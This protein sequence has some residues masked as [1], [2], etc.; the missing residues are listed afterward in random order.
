MKR[1]R[2]TSHATR[3][4]SSEEATGTIT[5]EQKMLL[6]SMITNGDPEVEE[7]LDQAALGNS[8][9]LKDLAL[10]GGSALHTRLRQL[11]NDGLLPLRFSRGSSQDMSGSV[12]FTIGAGGL[13]E[14]E[15]GGG[16]MRPHSLEMEDGFDLEALLKEMV[17]ADSTTESAHRDMGAGDSAR[18]GR[19]AT[20]A[21]D[22]LSNNLG[23]HLYFDPSLRH[24]FHANN[25][26]DLD[27]SNRG[28]NGDDVAR[29]AIAAA[30]M[31]HQFGGTAADDDEPESP[32][33]RTASEC[34]SQRSMISDGTGEGAGI[35]RSAERSGKAGLLLAQSRA[36]EST[37]RTE[38]SLGCGFQIIDNYFPD[39][40]NR[41]SAS[42]AD[43][44]GASQ[45][46]GKTRQ[47]GGAASGG[48][49]GGDWASR[50]LGESA[51][52]AEED[53]DAIERS[54]LSALDENGG[55]FVEDGDM[56]FEGL[57]DFPDMSDDMI[58]EDLIG[59]TSEDVTV[60]TKPRK[61]RQR[62][63]NAR[64]GAGAGESKS[65]KAKPRTRRSSK[66]DGKSTGG[67]SS[68]SSASSPG[69]FGFNW[70]F[71]L[72]RGS[73]VNEKVSGMTASTWHGAQGASSVT[74]PV[75][76]PMGMRV[77]QMNFVAP[78][79][80]PTH[81]RFGF[82]QMF[83]PGMSPQGGN[84]Q[85]PQQN[86]SAYVM[87]QGVNASWHAGM[88]FQPHALP[89]GMLPQQFS[90]IQNTNVAMRQ[91]EGS[92]LSER[93]RGSGSSGGGETG[94][95]LRVGALSERADILQER[96]LLTP[97]QRGLVQIIFRRG[98][99]YLCTRFDEAMTE[100]EAGRTDRL[101]ELLRMAERLRELPPPAGS[102][103]TALPA[104]QNLGGTAVNASSGAGSAGTAEAPSSTAAAASPPVATTA[105]AVEQLSI[106]EL[107]SGI[108]SLLSAVQAS[109][110]QAV[111][112]RNSKQ[113]D[114]A[115]KAMK[116]M[117]EEEAKLAAYQ[118]ALERRGGTRSEL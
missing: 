55:D 112:L 38:N 91:S 62:G 37:S 108:N 114:L 97:H 83:Q 11:S 13:A 46:G 69:S 99:D 27:M 64:R 84:L 20:R 32:R 72:T 78:Q 93:P 82:Q 79:S 4:L 115:L 117:K 44:V 42:P 41:G 36:R 110:A 33:K 65:A 59:Q 45:Q 51:D 22:D 100:A 109:K 70:P 77:N 58:S 95:S 25:S 63:T 21:V 80:M 94:R 102:S 48:G 19:D 8:Q 7:A 47:G 68:G 3:L 50:Q 60:D 87:P 75:M 29:E 73:E 43:K 10:N 111:E 89:S 30:A 24:S 61:G 96:G 39:A 107:R 57:F 9:R 35:P 49:S 81:G 18:G 52:N 34:S 40:S 15:S 31:Q 1:A 116:R 56:N 2:A 6:R 105:K 26:L 14:G 85:G 16:S 101:S 90:M 118:G 92:N 28:G 88:G 54:I 23:D 74:A 98:D 71:P 113:F 106:E 53:L 67:K 104:A 12:D 76:M 103:N 5:A 86:N 17:S 66:K